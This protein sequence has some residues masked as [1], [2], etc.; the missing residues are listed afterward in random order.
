LEA[1]GS[2][3]VPRVS[4]V[5]LATSIGRTQCSVADCI[6]LCCD[7]RPPRVLRLH[8]LVSSPKEPRCGC[9]HYGRHFLPQ[10][11]RLSPKPAI[12]AVEVSR[13]K[14]P[15]VASKT[16]LFART[17][18]SK[19]SSNFTVRKY[20][21]AW[22]NPPYDVARRSNQLKRV[23]RGGHGREPVLGVVASDH[24]VPCIRSVRPPPSSS[25]AILPARF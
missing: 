21:C 8:Q 23:A 10:V 3:P 14:P 19:G 16:I 18:G 11:R 12:T 17:G 25:S 24:H 1:P 4:S 22:C 5:V 15:C 13:R 9:S 6:R 20:R 7:D 2:I